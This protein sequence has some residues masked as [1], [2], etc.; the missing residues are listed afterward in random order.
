MNIKKKTTRVVARRR[1][2]ADPSVRRYRLYREPVPTIQ[3]LAPT[4]GH[5]KLPAP[6]PVKA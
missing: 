2:S 1:A 4:N 5:S 6:A 3:Q